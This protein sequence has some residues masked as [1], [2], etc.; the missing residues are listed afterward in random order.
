MTS[1]AIAIRNRLAE[2]TGAKFELVK[3]SSL[4]TLGEKAVWVIQCSEAKRSHRVDYA[5]TAWRSS[6]GSVW[7]RSISFGDTIEW[8]EEDY[9]EEALTNLPKIDFAD[10]EGAR[11]WL[12]KWFPLVEQRLQVYRKIAVE[13]S[14]D[15][16]ADFRIIH[17]I[18]TRVVT[19]YVAAQAYSPKESFEAN[20][21][22]LQAVV[23]ALKAALDDIY[24]YEISRNRNSNSTVKQ[25]PV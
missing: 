13:Y 6:D 17:A 7:I 16:N 4:S 12:A 2:I 9:G 1:E 18:G 11:A 19:F 22:K 3:P 10:F 8:I 15:F 20:P 14:Q 23:S 5:N 25:Q 24:D 21:Q